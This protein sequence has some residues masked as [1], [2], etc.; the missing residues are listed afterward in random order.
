[1]HSN[2]N[3]DRLI[4]GYFNEVQKKNLQTLNK[5]IENNSCPITW[6]KKK[7]FFKCTNKKTKKSKSKS[8]KK[9]SKKSNK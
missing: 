6:Y 1:M 8:S 7:K 3:I 4:E 5:I 9:S 2:P